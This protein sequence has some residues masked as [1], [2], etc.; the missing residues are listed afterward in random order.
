MQQQDSCDTATQQQHNCPGT[1]AAILYVVYLAGK[2]LVRKRS[3][4]QAMI[5]PTWRLPTR[6]IS[7]VHDCCEGV[8]FAELSKTCT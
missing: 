6:S 4:A 5:L 1:H 7:V 3:M 2:H 8:M